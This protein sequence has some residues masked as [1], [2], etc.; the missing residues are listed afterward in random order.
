MSTGKSKTAS[1]NL[2]F[3]QAMEELEQVIDRL[4]SGELGLEQA[5]NFYEKGIELGKRCEKLLK[6]AELRVQKLSEGEGGNPQV[7]P[8]EEP[9]SRSES[10][11]AD[12]DIPY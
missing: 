3:E 5:L 8:L 1:E 6:E 2:S 11:A 7:A 10:P 12:D 4:D 9:G